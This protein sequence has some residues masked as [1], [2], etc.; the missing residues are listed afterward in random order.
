MK[1]L[2]VQAN[3]SQ[4]DAIIAFVNGELAAY[5]C[6]MKARLEIEL[7]IEEIFANIASYAYRPG[8]GEAEIGCEVLCRPLGSRVFCSELAGFA[9]LALVAFLTGMLFYTVALVKQYIK[10]SFVLSRS[11]ALAIVKA[12]DTGPVSNEVMRIYR[13]LS[14]EERDK[15][16]TPEYRAHFAQVAQSEDFRSVHDILREFENS[17]GVDIY[18]AMYDEQT[19]A[20]VYIVDSDG[21]SAFNF[22][23]GEWKEVAEKERIGTELNM[24]ASI[25]AKM[26]PNIFPAFPEREEFDIYATMDPA[27]EV[28]GDF[29][30]FFMV[31]EDHLAMVVAD[32]SDKGVPAAFTPEELAFFGGKQ[33]FQTCELHLNPGDVILQY[34]DGVTEAT[35]AENELF[36]DERLLS[37]LNSA[38]STKPNEL[39]AY[40]RMKLDEFVQD[41]PQFDDITMLGLRMN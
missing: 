13:S 7:A 17:S 5:D 2:T 4:L 21:G 31:D 12:V 11:T 29:Y 23:P 35:T 34:T 16:G 40:I 28:G 39:L 25:Q 9:I 3:R 32:V 18:L 14:A 33:R 27:K 20:V 36:G 30:D 41:A 6:P 8:E 10:E 19:N 1:H 24:A 26:L 38:S 37:V 22:E 15:T